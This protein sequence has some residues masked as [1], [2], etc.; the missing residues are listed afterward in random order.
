MTVFHPLNHFF[1][2]SASSCFFCEASRQ[3]LTSKH[4][5]Q[6]DWNSS[7]RLISFEEEF[8]GTLEVPEVDMTC[9]SSWLESP[10]L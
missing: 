7:G 10:G 1:V 3:A 6:M 9:N 8:L 5:P 2:V 4:Q